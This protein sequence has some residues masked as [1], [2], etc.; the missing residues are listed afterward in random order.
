MHWLSSV[1]KKSDAFC[2]DSAT[3]RRPVC[4]AFAS[5]VKVTTML[6]IPVALLIEMDPTSRDFVRS[7]AV[8]KVPGP[9]AVTLKSATALPVIRTVAVPAVPP[10]PAIT[11]SVPVFAGVARAVG[12]NCTTTVQLAQSALA[13]SRPSEHVFTQLLC[14]E[15]MTK[16]GTTAVPLSTAIA[17]GPVF[18]EP[19]AFW[20]VNVIGLT[21]V[22][23]GATGQIDF[24]ST[25]CEPKS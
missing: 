14:A 25:A 10:A 23:A 5:F 12:M 2:P 8:A 11:V 19:V 4:G 24:D 22:T 21:G 7:V 20:K 1:T 9:A 6:G 15:S 18:S 17:N 13:E 3:D 16:S